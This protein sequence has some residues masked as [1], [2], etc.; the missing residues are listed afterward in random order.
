MLQN[1]VRV[2]A[3]AVTSHSQNLRRCISAIIHPKAQHPSQ[4]HSEESELPEPLGLTPMI[5]GAKLGNV[6]LQRDKALHHTTHSYACTRCNYTA[7]VA[8]LREREE[9]ACRIMTFTDWRPLM[10]GQLSTCC[11]KVPNRGKLI[12][13]ST[14]AICSATAKLYLSF[15]QGFFTWSTTYRF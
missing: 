10:N 2:Q 9:F 3:I 4:H 11:W 5:T 7:R 1:T 8:D 12:S 13:C 15:P 14:V 6:N